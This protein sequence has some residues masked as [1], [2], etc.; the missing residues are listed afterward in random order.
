M[1]RTLLQQ[2]HNPKNRVCG[3]QADCWC[4]RTAI[5]RLVKWWLPTDRAWIRHKDGPSGFVTEVER[6]AWRR[7]QEI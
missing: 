6:R 7:A 2:I 4:L 1:Q 5:G 3:C